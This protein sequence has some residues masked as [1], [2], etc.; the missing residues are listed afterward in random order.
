M[1]KF[2]GYKPLADFD[3]ETG[4]RERPNAYSALGADIRPCPE[5]GTPAGLACRWPDG[6]PRKTPHWSRWHPEKVA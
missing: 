4:S 2:E 1:R 3:E 5:C 6:R